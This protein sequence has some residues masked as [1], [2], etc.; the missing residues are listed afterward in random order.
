MLYLTIGFS[1]VLCCKFIQK[2][3]E[4]RVSCLGFIRLLKALPSSEETDISLSVMN[5][6]IS[7]VF[8]LRMYSSSCFVFALFCSSTPFYSC[9]D[10]PCFL[11]LLDQTMYNLPITRDLV[12]WT[13]HVHHHT[14]KGGGSCLLCLNASYAHGEQQG[15]PSPALYSLIMYQL[16]DIRM[17]R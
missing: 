15:T 13:K 7:R 10:V 14:V 6:G 5:R 1:R 2:V 4:F 17:C 16:L 11:Q 9:Y 12:I 3:S 8:K